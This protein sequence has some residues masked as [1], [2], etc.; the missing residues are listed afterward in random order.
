VAP[1]ASTGA[2]A[3]AAAAP[4][5]SAA[6]PSAA[7]AGGHGAA[8]AAAIAANPAAAEVDKELR[9]ARKRLRDIDDTAGKAAAGAALDEAQ[10]RKVAGRAAVAAHV[11]DLVKQ[12][13]AMGIAV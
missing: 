7:A 4:A 10:T 8:A 2:G 6:A 9:R 3:S 12:L 5:G 1:A 13:A 11:A